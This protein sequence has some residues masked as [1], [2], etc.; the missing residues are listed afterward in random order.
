[1]RLLK[2]HYFLAMLSVGL[3]YL[4]P[5]AEAQ[6]SFEDWK[7][8]FYDKAV[9]EGVS[10]KQLS[11]IMQMTPYEKAIK[12]DQNQVEFKHFL[13]DYLEKV[14]S[15]SRIK[16]GQRKFLI[17]QLLLNNIAET[18]GVASQIIVAIWGIETNYG[19]F[20]GKVPVM[21]A[22]ATLAYEGR[23]QSFFEGELIAALKLI[24]YGDIINFDVKGSWAGGLG[25]P[26]FIP[27][28]Y[29]H[30]GV[31]YDGDGVVN[32]WQTDDA[33]ASIGHYLATLGWQSGV[34]WGHEVEVV[35][36]FDYLLANTGESRTV[37]QWADLG[38][39]DIGEKALFNKEIV[40]HLFV[41]AGQYGPKFLLY[42]NFNV[43]KRY[44]NSD[45][46]AL[47][48]GLLSNRIAGKPDLMTPWPNNAKQFTLNDMKIVQQILADLGF[49]TN[50]IDGIFG[51]GTRRAL[52]AYQAENDL[53]ADGFLTDDLYQK[54]MTNL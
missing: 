34:G 26:Q 21:R 20:M 3:V 41:P 53:V 5:I 11:N 4:L 23:R 35:P 49:Y 16:E 25:M 48:V 13:W 45:A 14:I 37:A 24:D 33:L 7:I 40:A 50:K 36:N 39:T 18:T 29:I 6:Q 15:S 19:G 38:V 9:A 22:M 51:N 10:Q 8:Q 27:T 12:I 43:I 47:A 44:N 2:K 52:Q 32:L 1:M 28:S 30:Y 31:D 42:K 46:Y 54:L 17:E